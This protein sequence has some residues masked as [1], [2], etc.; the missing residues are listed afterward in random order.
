MVLENKSDIG[1]ENKYKRKVKVMEGV[2]DYPKNK[3]TED[4]LAV[5]GGRGCGGG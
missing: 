2:F 3:D 4:K 5:V 1:Y